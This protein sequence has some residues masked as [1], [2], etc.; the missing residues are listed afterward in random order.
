MSSEEERYDGMLLAMAQQTGGI[1]PLL[2]AI[3]G[4]LGRKTDFF[5]YHS[6]P[7]V[8]EDL[9]VKVFRTHQDR[10]MQRNRKA[11]AGKKK[12]AEKEKVLK[13][14]QAAD[15]LKRAKEAEERA[16]RAKEEAARAREAT[17]KSKTAPAL[18]KTAVDEKVTEFGIEEIE[19]DDEAEQGT[20]PMPDAPSAEKAEQ[21]G[22]GERSLERIHTH[23]HTNTHTP[24]PTHI[25][26]H[27][28][29]GIPEIFRICRPPVHIF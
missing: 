3:F 29:K 22:V 13:Q 17:A 5:K 16:L 24:T 7:Q 18:T 27:T 19:S 21:V 11:E 4:F 14:K 15:Q 9:V 8:A 20:E 2:N 12:Q 23:T 6:S 25:H 26:P 10:A 28:H 1:E